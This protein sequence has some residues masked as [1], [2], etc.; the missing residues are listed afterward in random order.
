MKLGVYG[1]WKR[2]G[3]M[4]DG[5]VVD[6]QR[7][8]AAYLV[9]TE[10]EPR[11]YEMA[12]ALVGWNLEGFIAGGERSAKIA[13][14]VNE[15]A[16]RRQSEGEWLGVQ[17]EKIVQSTSALRLHAPWL[18]SAK[19][20]CAGANFSDHLSGMFSRIR[21]AYI[22]PQD[23]AS[24]ARKENAWG[25]YKLGSSIIGP[26]DPV[27][28]PEKT[29]RLD[30][31]GEVAIIFGKKGKDIRASKILDYVLGYTLF[32]DFSIRDSKIDRGGFLNFAFA[33]NFEGAGSLGP[34][35]TLKDD[36]EDPQNIEFTTTVNGEKRQ[37]GNT[38][39]MIRSFGE[40]LELLSA[41]N[42]INPG[43]ILAS[44][45]CAGTAA[46]STPTDSN[47]NQDASRFLKPGDVVEVR[48]EKIGLLRNG[49]LEKPSH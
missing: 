29:A 38:K 16:M 48:A 35:I 4:N 23:A 27:L 13:R 7:A 44:G 39:D 15:Y 33:K 6:L 1:P 25:F 12:E 22:S 45:T 2:L 5:F 11:P 24:E 30:F 21:G 46:D 19:V 47:G 41:D 42:V 40:F 17:A 9:E 3:I 49:I 10:N 36:I 28:Y 26:E 34:W 32:N 20:M 14:N 43:D 31:E 18:K 8:C 37:K